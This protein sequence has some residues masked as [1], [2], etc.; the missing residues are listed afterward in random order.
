MHLTAADYHNPFTIY[1][2]FHLLRYRMNCDKLK[3]LWHVQHF[4]KSRFHMFFSFFVFL[5]PIFPF[6]QR[7]SRMCRVEFSFAAKWSILRLIPAYA[8]F[9]IETL[10]FR[11]VLFF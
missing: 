6:A 11:T 4:E 8:V 10:E 1:F 9:L 2:P 7:K 5:I 3:R